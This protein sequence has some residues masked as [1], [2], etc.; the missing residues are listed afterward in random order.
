MVIFA[1][2][3]VVQEGVT[4]VAAN[5]AIVILLS[6]LLFAAVA[7]HL[8]AGERMTVNQFAGGSLIVIATLLSGNL[9]Q[10]A[11]SHDG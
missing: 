3:L 8:L 10:P 9:R 11:P 4:R 2:N 6:E 5:Q 7:A 1:T